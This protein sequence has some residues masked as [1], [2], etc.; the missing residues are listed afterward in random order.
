MDFVEELR[1]ERTIPV[2][3]LTLS[4]LG[5]KV[6]NL[7]IAESMQRVGGEHVQLAVGESLTT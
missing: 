2:H 3:E 1:P 7:R 6:S 4:E 5:R